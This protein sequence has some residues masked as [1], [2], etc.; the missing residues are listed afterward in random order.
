MA[1]GTTLGIS[2]IG[3]QLVSG[4]LLEVLDRLAAIRADLCDGGKLVDTFNTALDR[5]L[6]L[7]QDTQDT[8]H[9]LGELTDL[10]ADAPP[11]ITEDLG[12]AGL[13]AGVETLLGVFFQGDIRQKT[14][15][16]EAARHRV[17]TLLPKLVEDLESMA[18][19]PRQVRESIDAARQSLLPSLVVKYQRDYGARLNALY[20]IR[21]VQ[22]QP[23][24]NWP[25][26]LATTWGET[27][28][29]FESVVSAIA[30]E[31]Q[32]FFAGEADT[33]FEVFVALCALDLEQQPIDW[34]APEYAPHARVLMKKRL[35]RLELAS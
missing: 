22:G 7:R 24:P 17:P 28:A 14:D 29:A 33:T 34:Q 23:V 3:Y 19:Q 20:R 26:R 1:L 15:E 25:D 11:A 18:D 10:L 4:K 12:L 5:F 35:L 6:V 27:V 30:A 21:R 9:R 8:A 2:T 31:G 32:A 16:R 13:N